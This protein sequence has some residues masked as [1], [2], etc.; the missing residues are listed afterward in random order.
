MTA[1]KESIKNSWEVRSLRFIFRMIIVL[2]CV[3]Y[4]LLTFGGA[5]NWGT[6]KWVRAQPLENLTS[7]AAEN[8]KAGTPEKISRWIR[9][10][11]AEERPRIIDM[12]KPSAS[13]LESP[14]FMMFA[15]WEDDAG[16]IDESLFWHQFARYRMRYDALRCGFV[17]AT[18]D[19]TGLLA[20]VPQEHM[21]KAVEKD[22]N[23]TAKSIQKVLDFDANYPAQNN[24]RNICGQLA[25]L[26]RLTKTRMV[27]EDKWAEIRHTLR[28][29]T[30]SSLQ[31][32]KKK[33]A[34]PQEKKK[35]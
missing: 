22:P 16:H 14:T 6:M 21:R 4:L 12:L 7:Y 20:L 29:V 34:A 5:V 35:N 28:S 11:P 13:G 8:I 31:D 26:N 27:G 19:M 23:F 18:D 17:S 2:F 1:L 15:Q 9:F 33:T 25:Q 10:R 32:M 30:E 3:G 24:P